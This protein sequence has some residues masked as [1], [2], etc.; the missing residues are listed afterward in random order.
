M[1]KIVELNADE[2]TEVTGGR[3][4]VVQWFEDVFGSPDSPPDT[5]IFN[6]VKG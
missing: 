6:G 4:V 2:V 1:S 3:N 5:W